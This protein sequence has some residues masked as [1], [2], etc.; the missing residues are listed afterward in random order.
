[1]KKTGNDPCLF[2]IFSFA[3]LF[4]A[5]N[6]SKNRSLEFKTEILTFKADSTSLVN[7]GY[8]QLV[9]TDSGEFLITYNGFTRFFEFI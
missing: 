7:S 9:E 8:T 2:Y 6:K 5:C 4:F 1:M 3:F